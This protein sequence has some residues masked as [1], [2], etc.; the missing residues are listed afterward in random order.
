MLM[1]L[2]LSSDSKKYFFQLLKQKYNATS[3]QTLSKKLNVSIKTL[4]SWF[5]LKDRCIP[6]EF[7]D[8][9]ILTQLKVIDV[10]EN[11]WGQIK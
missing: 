8:K 3:I 11:N 2:L 6:E 1:R 4:E 9:D 10:R 7:I 5:Y